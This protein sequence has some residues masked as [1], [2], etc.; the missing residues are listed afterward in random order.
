[1]N[2]NAELYIREFN[3]KYDDLITVNSR[4]KLDR[5]QAINYVENNIENINLI[6][7]KIKTKFNLVQTLKNFDKDNPFKNK[8][9]YHML[10]SEFC[11]IIQR[12]SNY[13]VRIKYITRSNNCLGEKDIKIFLQ[14][15]DNIKRELENRE[16]LKNKSQKEK[17]EKGELIIK[18]DES[19]SQIHSIMDDIYDLGDELVIKK[20]D[21]LEKYLD[22]L[23]S[24]EKNIKKIKLL[25]SKEW[26][27]IQKKLLNVESKT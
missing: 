12:D 22:D 2:I 14:E 10:W 25:E 8:E 27:R 7:D 21:E 24:E 16:N 17:L 13:I 23:S 20:R 6:K 19:I 26:S 5:Y 4:Q 3:Q 9:M 1:M 15:F 18:K 11:Q